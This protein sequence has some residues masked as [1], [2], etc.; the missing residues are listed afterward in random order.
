MERSEC[1]SAAEDPNLGRTLRERYRLDERIG[2]GAMGAV[3][4]AWDLHRLQPC[5]VKLLRLQ[6]A[7]RESIVVRFCDEARIVAQLC[8]PN[9]VELYDQGEEDDGTLFLT[10][11]LLRGHDLYSLL[12]AQ[13]G[14]RLAGC[15]R[16]CGRLAVRCRPCTSPEW[17]TAI[18][19]RG[20]SF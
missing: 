1:A 2:S 4:R 13:T 6:A 5:A 8:H 3:Y 20:I 19:S 7:E 12:R 17:S 11:E 18:S 16:S 9:I 14:C 10:M 15:W